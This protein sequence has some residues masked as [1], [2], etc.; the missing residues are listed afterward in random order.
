M[1]LEKRLLRMLG[2]LLTLVQFIIAPL[3][4]AM[5]HCGRLTI[6]PFWQIRRQVVLQLMLAMLIVAGVM[7][8]GNAEV[9]LAA[10]GEG[11]VT[12]YTNIRYMGSSQTFCSDSSSLG[13]FDNDAVSIEVGPN[14]TVTLYS[15]S[16]YDGET[17]TLT[18]Q[19]GD[20]NYE[21]CYGSG[22]SSY[23]SWLGSASS[24]RI[25][26]GGGGGGG[27]I[28]D[29]DVRSES[30]RTS[31]PYQAGQTLEVRAK[32]D[33]DGDGAV[34]V[35]TRLCA[36]VSTTKEGEPIDQ[37][38]KRCVAVP[39]IPA[40][41][42]SDY[43]YWDVPVPNSLNPGTYYM[44]FEVDST[45]RVQE[46]DEGDNRDY[47]S[48]TIEAQATPADPKLVGNIS[49]TPT[50]LTHG[51][52]SNASYTIKNYGDEPITFNTISISCRA[53]DGSNCDFGAEYNLTLNGGQSYTLNASQPN[54]G[55]S[56]QYGEYSLTASYR[57]PDGSW[58]DFE[59]SNAKTVTVQVQQAEDEYCAT[60]LSQNGFQ[61][62]GVYTFDIPLG[63]TRE[64]EVAFQNDCVTKWERDNIMLAVYEPES[65]SDP[66]AKP[67][68][69]PF[70]AGTYA[71]PYADIPGWYDYQKGLVTKPLETE[72]AKGQKATFK[73]K[74]TANEGVPGVNTDI[75]HVHFVL[76]YRED[77]SSILWTNMQSGDSAKGDS[78]GYATSWWEIVDSN[79][80]EASQKDPDAKFDFALGYEAAWVSQTLPTD[81]GYIPSPDNSLFFRVSP[82]DTIKFVA[83]FKNKG[84]KTWYNSNCEDEDGNIQSRQVKIH[85]YK[86]IIDDWSSAPDESSGNISPFD[87]P[88]PDSE[89]NHYP[90]WGTSYFNEISQSEN[91]LMGI[92]KDPVVPPGEIGTFEFEITVPDDFPVDQFGKFR[93][94]ISLAAGPYWIKNDT[95]G[96]P[97]N[98]AHIWFGLD[99]LPPLSINLNGPDIASTNDP[100]V[101]D[102][103]VKNE[104]MDELANIQITNVLPDGTS[105]V[106][107]GTPS[108]NIVS[109]SV[110]SLESG[111]D[112]T[113]EL[114][115]QATTSIGPQQVQ[116]KRDPRIIGGDEAQISDWPWMVALVRTITGDLGDDE[117]ITI[118][119]INCGGVLID[120][121]WVLTA[122][123]CLELPHGDIINKENISIV[124]GRN[125][126]QMPKYI[127]ND[128][129]LDNYGEF[130][131]NSIP[132]NNRFGVSD[133]VLHPDY[134]SVFEGNDIALIRLSTPSS[135]PNISII[136]SEDIDLETEGNIATVIGRGYIGIE[137]LGENQGFRYITTDKLHQ[138]QF[139]IISNE[140]CASL[141]EGFSSIT[142]NIICTAN[143]E[144][145][146][147]SNGDSGGP[148]VVRRNLNS[149]WMLVGIVSY[150][151]DA[152]FDGYTRVSKFRDWINQ[153]IS[154][155]KEVIINR[156]Y[157]VSVNGKS[158]AKGSR[159]V[160]TT[161]DDN[162]V[163]DQTGGIIQL[164]TGVRMEVASD[165]FNDTVT[166][167]YIPQS[168]TPT[169]ELQHANEFYE[170]YATDSNGTKTQPNKPYNIAITYDEANLSSGLDESKLALYFKNE[171]GQW[172]LEPT[173]SVDI[174]A[175]VVTA[176][177]DHFSEWAVL[178]EASQ[179]AQPLTCG[180]ELS[181]WQTTSTLPQ[182]RSIP[183][184]H[185]E[186]LIIHN[187]F[188]Y[189][190]GGVNSDG[191]FTN[192]YYAAIAAD[193]T[194]GTWQETT[195]FPRTYYDFV[196]TRVGNYVYLVTG[197]SG[198]ADVH[199]APIETDGSI[200]AWVKTESLHP[201]RQ[202]FAVTSYGDYIYLSGGNAVGTKDFV[203]FSK[204]NADGSLVGWQDTTVLPKPTEAHAMVQ[205]NGY[206][207][208]LARSGKSYY[209][210]IN[211][212]GTVGNWQETTVF[213]ERS[214]SRY[215]AFV[216]ADYLY[217]TGHDGTKVAYA[218]ILVDGQL[219]EWQQTTPLPESR[220]R[221]LVGSNGCQAYAIGGYGGGKHQDTV[222]YAEALEETTPLTLTSLTPDIIPAG[223]SEL[224]MVLYG[225]G[226][227]EPL[228]ISLGG[229]VITS[230]NL[231]NSNTLM[232]N[233]ALK[234]W[235]IGSYDLALTSADRTVVMTN[236]FTVIPPPVPIVTSV[237]P[238]TAEVNTGDVQ[239]TVGGQYLTTP[240][241]A[242]M[243]NVM[244]L[245]PTLH[246]DKKATAFVPTSH[247]TEGSYTFTLSTQAGTA[248]FS[249]PFTITP[250]SF[251]P[252]A[253][254]L[255]IEVEP[256]IAI[257]S[258]VYLPVVISNATAIHGLHITVQASDTAVL[259]A[260]CDLYPRPGPGN[261]LPAG[262][263][264]SD[265]VE[266]KGYSY[267]VTM[268]FDTTGV[269]GSGTVIELP[270]YAVG[271]GTV[272]LTF[273]QHELA[274]QQ[275]QL[276]SHQTLSASTTVSQRGR[277][278]GTISTEYPAF[279]PSLRVVLWQA[280][281]Y[282]TR[283]NTINGHYGFYDLPVGD[284]RIE[285]RNLSYPSLIVPASRT[286]I[287]IK[288][289]ELTTQDVTLFVGDITG[290][291]LV[292]NYDWALL[293]SAVLSDN[294]LFDLTGDGAATL[295]DLLALEKN[296]NKT[297]LSGQDAPR[298]AQARQRT[299]RQLPETGKAKL[300]LLK[301][302]TAGQWLL[303]SSAVEEPLVSV[304]LQV[305]IP[306]G[307]AV[308][309]VSL[310]GQFIDGFNSWF[311]DETT[312]I[313][314]IVAAPPEGEPLKAKPDQ[315]ETIVRITLN[316]AESAELAITTFSTIHS[317]DLP[318]N[319]HYL[320]TIM[321]K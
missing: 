301:A 112:I 302:D 168:P 257:D 220:N 123:H 9:V 144:E 148:L 172:T 272:E 235:P 18:G 37:A 84:E 138:A 241:T 222:F 204:V 57:L 12:L 121:E 184:E 61:E 48:F 224:G 188:A 170:I 140:E 280:D 158:I 154:R 44:V 16:N 33:N 191:Y 194:L 229:Q 68:C 72:T 277:L 247:F 166:I 282:I 141:A 313:L 273:S 67:L 307:V 195:A 54:F 145:R 221:V 286:S 137:L 99:V 113:V 147:S 162:K 80:C 14:T 135:Q 132:P 228:Q 125:V 169:G 111:K 106:S 47:D 312:N 223:D 21:A 82:G 29:L 270:F 208:V 8:S 269:N 226:I 42:N 309:E 22:C 76:K 151:D 146:Q 83:E 193:G 234:E 211:S 305:D 198:S 275:A 24:L 43:Y 98:V 136:N 232:F 261:I 296:R 210:A 199:Y 219:G 279:N 256:L 55:V 173:S 319:Y 25:T 244:L 110:D 114:T 201:S 181:N 86:D 245:T 291:G 183:F 62:D 155:D 105:Y 116:T 215:S 317:S 225:S 178:G 297:G 262:Q 39:P 190:F 258:V 119:E 95:N 49:T 32:A 289:G 276:L 56:N 107:G 152:T 130:N 239:V 271:E 264:Q 34:T 185:G 205:H 174:Q 236:A 97:L 300:S 180:P 230:Y 274:N 213:Y 249:M 231:I 75:C 143:E 217:L 89:G 117:K 164:E 290:D 153:N 216:M 285:I 66:D 318:K 122:A 118:T 293:A 157:R 35:T 303:L 316:Q 243:G 304:G 288:P 31:A 192:V 306:A 23:N 3:T 77:A 70:I 124:V 91:G 278:D 79:Q 202:N 200:G 175:N 36:W 2:H 206:L 260:A 167:H 6:K 17:L 246:S 129:G 38:L 102:L 150:G 196:V 255:A 92:L 11:C 142:D 179:T 281:Q 96:D 28:P 156:D 267:I 45:Q 189:V 315:V 4:Q 131:I 15:L 20:L 81:A 292:N 63:E 50:T 311:Q 65:S 30:I 88:E 13:S 186:T 284:Y 251:D 227:T 26:T 187:G 51:E 133:I 64:F 108:G 10:P 237:T 90:E 52:T 295:L 69:G 165:T 265:C 240:F 94:D 233:I 127:E 314:Y 321:T 161:L 101:Y 238:L 87:N 294:Y 19:H 298:L 128:W 177:P 58:H 41:D 263:S 218:P 253:L 134:K 268:P 160:L 163:V 203:K 287:E 254:T 248:V 259:K 252:N 214:R 182:G 120:P 149:P 310:A 103:T 46:S 171:S 74:M 266:S 40:N 100:L 212:D 1:M 109:W 159:A 209:S 73:F 126:L 207:Y 71:Y 250:P 85:V 27:G 283:T 5:A 176:N 104:S 320:P 59:P 299:A 60:W 7:V 308:T 115:V 197:A 242:T 139:S 93:E 53:P 78:R